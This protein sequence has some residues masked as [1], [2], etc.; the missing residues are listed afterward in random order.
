MLDSSREFFNCYKKGIRRIESQDLLVCLEVSVYCDLI[1]RLHVCE[2][3]HYNTERK[4]T[5]HVP[6]MFILNKCIP[7]RLSIDSI[8]DDNNL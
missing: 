2:Y 6:F 7:S 3:W 8:V 5:M 1:V 4:L